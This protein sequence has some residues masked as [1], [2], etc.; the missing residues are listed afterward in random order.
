MKVTG[1]DEN[2]VTLSGEGRTERIES[3]TVIW[4]AGVAPSGFGKILAEH[5]G[6]KLDRQGRVMVAQDL[7][8]EGHPGNPAIGDLAHVAGRCGASSR[9]RAGSDATRGVC[10]LRKRRAIPRMNRGATGLFHQ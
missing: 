4:A 10:G 5:T 7:T 1:I 6:A 2:G 8:I 3:R 9:S